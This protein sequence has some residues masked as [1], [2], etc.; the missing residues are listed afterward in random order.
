MSLKVNDL[1]M[2]SSRSPTA[3]DAGRKSA[4]RWCKYSCSRMT[5]MC[6]QRLQVLVVSDG[7]AHRYER[8][9]AH[10]Y[11]KLSC[12]P[13]L[14]ETRWSE[15]FLFARLAQTGQGCW[16]SWIAWPAFLAGHTPFCF[17]PQHTLPC[18]RSAEI[19]VVNSEHCFECCWFLLSCRRVG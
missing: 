16:A 9:R 5:T 4:M 10:G 19:L 3:G 13:T 1:G 8:R 14:E 7:D 11:K 2:T 6:E 18:L 17:A 15:S 12:V